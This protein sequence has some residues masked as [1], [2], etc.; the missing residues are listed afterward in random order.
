MDLIVVMMVKMHDNFKLIFLIKNLYFFLI[1]NMKNFILIFLSHFILDFST[2]KC[3][4][5]LV[6]LIEIFRHGS[7]NPS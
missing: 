2:I 3:D 4:D 6:M 7:R 5:E 1:I